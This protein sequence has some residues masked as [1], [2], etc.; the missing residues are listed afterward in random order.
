M[1]RINLRTFFAISF[2][3][4]IVL[5]TASLTIVLSMKSSNE[6]KDEIG[7]STSNIAYQ[8]SDKLDFFMWSR[9]SEIEMLSQ[10]NLFKEDQNN[11]DKKILINS[12]QESIPVFS[13]VG[14]TDA[15][16]NIVVS[17]DDIL[18]GANIAE[19]PVFKEATKQPF[20]GDVHEA[21][22][23]AELLPN[24]SGVPLEFVDISFPIFNQNG[25]FKGVLA[26]HLSWEWSRE[27][28]NSIIKPYQKNLDNSKQMEVFIV[29][30]SDQTILLGPEKMLGK[31]LAP[32][33][34]KRE[35][36]LNNSWEIK[37]WSDGKEYLTGYSIGD[38]YSNYPGLDWT[39][40]VRIPVEQ[41]FTSVENLQNYTILIG[42]I[43]A[44]IFAIL[45]WFLASK[46]STPLNEISKAANQLK[47]GN[48]VDIPHF[49]RIKDL[50]VLSVSLREMV[51]TITETKSELGQMK[52]LAHKDSLTGLPNRIALYSYIDKKLESEADEKYLFLFLDLDG[53][54][55]VND[56]FGHQ[57]GDQLLKVVANRLQQIAEEADFV[58][59]LGGDEF[60][61]IARSKTS[62]PLE[63]GK[64]LGQQI[65]ESINKSISLNEK[66]E[67]VIKC[68][69]GGAIWPDYSIEPDDIIQL[70]DEA[71]Y[72]SKRTGKNKFTFYKN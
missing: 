2:L 36:A 11:N 10:L 30:S 52:R 65:I 43:A 55:D 45:G 32:N 22:L 6:I 34:L 64:K 70:A 62:S 5:L 1:S 4:F 72:Q 19:R 20:I 3:C 31:T 49:K 17:T 42:I 51:A 28:E 40:I 44:V 66:D 57:A 38:G 14:L 13:W 58:G 71:L 23:L 48:K 63:E 12:L 69:I 26:T 60:I 46:I 50:H 16:G 67:V 15:N 47:E 21:V 25:D 24:P 35:Y 53:F 39:I 68:S 8:M 7:D 29:S 59:R 54:K 18:T 33:I 56:T 27:I 9:Y 37:K 41:A 61:I